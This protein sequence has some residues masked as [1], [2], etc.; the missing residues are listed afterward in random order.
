MTN[1]VHSSSS[2]SGP[3]ITDWKSFLPPSSRHEFITPVYEDQYGLNWGPGLCNSIIKQIYHGASVIPRG[4]GHI[5]SLGHLF[6]ESLT[7][8]IKG[9]HAMSHFIIPF[10]NFLKTIN[11]AILRLKNGWICACTKVNKNYWNGPRNLY[12]SW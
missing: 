8:L 10:S 6:S 3:I 1:S 11:K 9:Q 7:F 12:F 4:L 5:T 2:V